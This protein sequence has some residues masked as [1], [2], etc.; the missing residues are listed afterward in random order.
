MAH[1]ETSSRLSLYASAAAVAA[2][3]TGTAANA[4]LIITDVGTTFTVSPVDPDGFGGGGTFLTVSSTFGD[5]AIQLGAFGAINFYAAQFGYQG[6][7][8]SF[9]DFAGWAV[10]NFDQ[11]NTVDVATKF[12]KLRHFQPG[13]SVSSNSKVHNFSSSGTG[14]KSKSKLNPEGY[15]STKAKGVMEGQT[16]IGLKLLATEVDGLEHQYNYG[17]LDVTVGLNEEDRFFLTVN[18]WA[19]ESEVETAAAI[20]GGSVVPGV[21]GLAALAF[22][23]AGIRRRRERVA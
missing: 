1:A 18:R 23:A 13:D 12:G 5:A 19:Y 14:G 2:V 9:F 16:Y 21:G 6:T 11:S 7:A 17:W 10:G 8:S 4:D 15:S 20:P 22:G 3:G